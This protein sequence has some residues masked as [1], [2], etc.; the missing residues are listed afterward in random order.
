[1]FAA[2]SRRLPADG[3]PYAY[4]RAAF[5]NGVGFAN[6]VVALVFSILFIGYSRNGGQEHWYVSRG[7]FLMIVAALL[8]GIPVYLSLRI[9]MTYARRSPPVTEQLPDPVRRATQGIHRKYGDPDE[10]PRRIR[11]RSAPPGDPAP[12]G[13]GTEPPDAGQRP[14]SPLR[15]HLVGRTGTRGARRLRADPAR[16]RRRGA[17][18]RR[19]VQHGPGGSEGAGMGARPRGDRGHGGPHAGPAAAQARGAGGQRTPRRVPHRRDH[20]ERAGSPRGQQ[21]AVGADEPGRLP[22]DPAAQPPLPA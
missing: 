5:G 10:V 22:A 13:C 9:R 18:L 16:P 12:T 21:P 3:G 6:A 11:G 14:P 7:P 1:M 20:Q 17:L 19:T 15:R 8:L 4:V 2:L